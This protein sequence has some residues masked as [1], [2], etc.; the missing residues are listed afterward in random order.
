M[1]DRRRPTPIVPLHDSLVATF[2]RRELTDE[3]LGYW[4]EVFSA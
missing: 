1:S 4:L 3:R 2:A